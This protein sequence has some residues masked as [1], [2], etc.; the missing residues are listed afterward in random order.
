MRYLREYLREFD[1]YPDQIILH[2][3]KH[4]IFYQGKHTDVPEKYLDYYVLQHTKLNRRA[5]VD[6]IIVEGV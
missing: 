4:G 5:K 1:F 6:F 3:F 2:K